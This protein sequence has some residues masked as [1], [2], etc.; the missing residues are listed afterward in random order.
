[1]PDGWQDIKKAKDSVKYD[2]IPDPYSNAPAKEEKKTKSSLKDIG[3]K[4][5]STTVVKKPNNAEFFDNDDDFDW[6]SNKKVCNT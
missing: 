6:D 4:Q 5:K 3:R 1:M 2:D